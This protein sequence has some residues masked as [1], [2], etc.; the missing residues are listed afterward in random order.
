VF[1]AFFSFFLAF[2]AP[3]DVFDGVFDAMGPP[4][5]GVFDAF[6]SFF[7][8]FDV[9]G[10]PFDAF[11]SFFRAF[12]A[13]FGVFAR[14][15]KPLPKTRVSSMDRV[16]K[17]QSPFLL[18]FFAVTADDPLP[19]Q[20]RSSGAKAGSQW[21]KSGHPQLLWISLHPVRYFV[22]PLRIS[23]RFLRDFAIPEIS[24]ARCQISLTISLHCNR[25]FV[26]S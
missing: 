2:D 11:F 18:F 21:P 6:S 15:A 5:E 20:W 23:L 4:F 1:D 7:L 12:D 14:W 10:T 22:A 19:V 3:F 24:S 25:Y 13:P 17:C 8:V 26:I 9:T 16:G